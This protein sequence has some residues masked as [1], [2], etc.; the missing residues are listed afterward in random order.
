MRAVYQKQDY[1]LEWP[2]QYEKRYGFDTKNVGSRI[3]TVKPHLADT[4]EIRTSTVIQ[5]CIKCVKLCYITT[6]LRILEIR[7]PNKSGY[8]EWVPKVSTLE[9]F[10][11]I[12]R[13]SIASSDS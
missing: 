4:L 6:F 13:T 3:C 8:F 11:C 2:K 12:Q 9:G 1:Q 5:H 7:T 10:H